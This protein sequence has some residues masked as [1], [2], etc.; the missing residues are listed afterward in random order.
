M[1]FVSFPVPDREVPSSRPE[2]SA[3]AHLLVSRVSQGKTAAVHCRAGIGRSSVIAACAL[4][5]LGTSP[6]C[7][8]EMIARARGVE[9][10]D[11][12]EQ[13]A[14]VRAFADWLQSDMQRS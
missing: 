10:P 8:F 7:A 9:V 12:E 11:T 3:L 13:R 6:D 4:V 14:W 5:C 2:A 1:E